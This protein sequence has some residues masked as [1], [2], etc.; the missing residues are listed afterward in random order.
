MKPHICPLFVLVMVA[1]ITFHSGVFANPPPPPEE[2]NGKD[3][4]LAGSGE[5]S[6]QTIISAPFGTSF[7]VN[8]GSTG[9]NMMGDAANE[10]SICIDPNDLNR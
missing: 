5:H 8:V 9:Q 3:P 10:P 7:Q 2:D 1:L 6:P 4:P